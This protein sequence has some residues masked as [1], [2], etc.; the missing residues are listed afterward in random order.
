LDTAQP[1]RRFCVLFCTPLA[2][3]L[4]VGIEVISSMINAEPTY[5]RQMQS[6]KLSKKQLLNNGQIPPG[7][8]YAGCMSHWPAAYGKK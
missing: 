6:G 7:K 3:Y 8:Q 1:G 5:V 2:L 4:D